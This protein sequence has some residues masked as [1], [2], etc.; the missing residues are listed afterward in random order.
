MG[1]QSYRSAASSLAK[2]NS[3]DEDFGYSSMVSRTAPSLF[4]SVLRD[5]T[6]GRGRLLEP[7]SFEDVDFLL[8]PLKL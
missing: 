7:P 1:K 4:Y 2:Q 5:E 8:Q 3:I 6:F